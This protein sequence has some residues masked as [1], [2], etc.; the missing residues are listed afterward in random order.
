MNQF[1]G[2][3]HEHDHRRPARCRHRRR[4]R[5]GDLIK[6]SE[7]QALHGRRDR[8]LA[9][10]AGDRRF[11]GAL[12]RPLQAAGPGAGEGGAAGQRQ[13]PH[14]ED[15]CR[16]EPA[17]RRPDAHPVDP[18]GLSP[19][20]TA[21]RSTASWARCPRAS[22]SSSSTVSAARAAW[23]RKSRPRWPRR[24]RSMEQ[25]DLQT[26][27]QIFAPGA[28]GRPRACRRARR[29]RA[30]PDCGGRS[31]ECQGHAGAGAA[32]QGQRS[33]RAERHGRA[34]PRAEPGRPVRDRQRC[35]AADRQEPR[36]F[37]GA[38]RPRR[39]AQRRGRARARPPTSCSTSSARSA[40]GTRRPRASSW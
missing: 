17:A 24:A 5:G 14:G 40:T 31:R 9:Q 33:R 34:R 36:R 25:D 19:S 3:S 29:P 30:L 23:P 15:Q 21:S 20:S 11:L 10:A 18:G 2:Y 1:E 4:R 35:K 6:D 12:V 27:A 13:G 8:G 26:A 22:S 7:H 32:G 38:A 37:P 16:R 39:A 28:A